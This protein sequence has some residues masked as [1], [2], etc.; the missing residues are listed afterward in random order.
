MKKREKKR[1][2][3]F[4]MVFLVFILIRKIRQGGMLAL[5]TFVALGCGW[6]FPAELQAR[7]GLSD[8]EIRA[9]VVADL[10]R[11]KAA[12]SSL[13]V[14]SVKNGV[15]RL[16]GLAGSSLAR[17]RAIEIAQAIA[18]VG[19]VKSS[20]KIKSADR[21]D[22]LLA[23]GITEEMFRAAAI[24]PAAG[25]NPAGSELE[26]GWQEIDSDT[27]PGEESSR[28]EEE[29]DE[30][31]EEAVP[32]GQ[33]EDAVEVEVN[34]DSG[35]V[36]LS[37]TVDSLQA[38][39]AAETAAL[40]TAGVGLVVNEIEV[41]SAPGVGDA[42]IVSTA[43][44]SLKQH[45][46]LAHYKFLLSSRSGNVNLYGMTD[47]ELAKE[48]AEEV[49][50]SVHGVVTVQNHIYVREQPPERSGRLLQCDMGK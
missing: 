24:A 9:A 27:W 36:T 45:P 33:L 49:V 35:S 8:R 28:A 11:D 17:E 39:L 46:D 10:V 20:I 23:A 12:S 14:V 37:G 16:D 21:L 4:R 43:K 50:R 25:G 30:P 6:G 1:A 34:A 32:S 31:F 13:L 2:A 41:S 42:G 22:N 48:Q 40:N 7:Q 3:D 18:G 29:I 5:L 15:V 44:A 26:R 38:S 19:S 47:T